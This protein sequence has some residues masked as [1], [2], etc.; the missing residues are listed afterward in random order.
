MQENATAY[1]SRIAELEGLLDR[2]VR[3]GPGWGVWVGG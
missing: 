1:L 3:A 2:Q